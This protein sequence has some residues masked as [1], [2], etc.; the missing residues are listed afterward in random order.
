MA[1]H[2]HTK[3]YT[4]SA[5]RFRWLWYSGCFQMIGLMLFD[6]EQAMDA[7]LLGEHFSAL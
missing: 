1:G 4:A 3:Q 6:T 7:P 2:V 5:F